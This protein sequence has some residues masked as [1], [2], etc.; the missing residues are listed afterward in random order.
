M[1]CIV[2]HI[3]GVLRQCNH[4]CQGRAETGEHQCACEGV[5]IEFKTSSVPSLMSC[6]LIHF[7]L[8]GKQLGQCDR[9]YTLL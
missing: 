6:D 1:V 2:V 9:L 3:H 8:N 5:E 4:Y 7:S